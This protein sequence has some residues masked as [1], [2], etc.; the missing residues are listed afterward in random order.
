LAIYKRAVPMFPTLNA[1]MELGFAALMQ[2]VNI[3]VLVVAMVV[4]WLV[5]HFAREVQ[6]AAPYALMALIAPLAQSLAPMT[7]VL[8][9]MGLLYGVAVP[10]GSRQQLTASAWLWVACGAVVAIATAMA[11]PWLA[12]LFRGFR[13][14][15]RVVVLASALVLMCA[16]A[17]WSP[18]PDRPRATAVSL[19]L[20]GVMLALLDTTLTDAPRDLT[21]SALSALTVAPLGAFL[22]TRSGSSE[23]DGAVAR[24]A[25]MARIGHG[26]MVLPW[27]LI[28]LPITGGAALIATVLRGHGMSAGPQMLASRPKLGWGLLL[29][30]LCATI[31]MYAL[32]FGSKRLSARPT[33][34]REKWV[35]VLCLLAAVGVLLLVKPDWNNLVVA[36]VIGAV[37]FGLALTGYDPSWL[38]AGWLVGHLAAPDVLRLFPAGMAGIGQVSWPAIGMF[39]LIVT[40]GVVWN[41]WRHL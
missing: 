36:G 35:A 30:A 29:A 22:L 33:V 31:V 13:P 37:A 7:S 21:L 11:A 9:L 19:P 3:G 40:L 34:R 18:H 2:P 17:W 24:G 39:V 26:T 5:A 4:G 16:A 23:N 15:D 28:G 1:S 25:S 27:I 14:V 38:V 8:L 41:R 20:L 10:H 12:E 32:R 6:S